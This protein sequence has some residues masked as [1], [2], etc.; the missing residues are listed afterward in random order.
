MKWFKRVVEPQKKWPFLRGIRI[1]QERASRRRDREYFLISFSPSRLW[2]LEHFDLKL[3]WST[4]PNLV[5]EAEHE[6]GGHFAFA[7]YHQPQE[8]VND[9]RLMFGKKGSAFGVVAGKTGY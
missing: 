7:A 5:C 1:S 4:A 2:S 6:S 3:R 9:L 8:L